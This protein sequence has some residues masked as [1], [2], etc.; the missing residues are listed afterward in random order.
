M[1]RLVAAT[2][3]LVAVGLSVAFSPVS[4]PFLATSSNGSSSPAADQYPAGFSESGVTNATAATVGHRDALLDAHNYSISY[5]A[6]VT[7]DDRT[8][9]VEFLER[10][11]ADGHR[12]YLRYDV[13][14]SGTT[15]YYYLND[16]VYAKRD[17]PGEDNTRY[18]NES[19]NFSIGRFTGARFV[20]PMTFNV[21]YGEATEVKVGGVRGYRYR[22]TAVDGAAAVLGRNVTDDQLR[23]FSATLVVDRHG[24]VRFVRYR[25]TIDTDDGTRSVSVRIRVLAVNATPVPEPGWIDRA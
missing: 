7:E 16:T 23:N 24:I 1:R 13:T 8:S 3:V 5:V 25:A 15:V 4:L 18:A 20:S 21:T 9:T 11:D 22:S 6:N 12:V 14:G 10:V 2:V 17:P 19:R